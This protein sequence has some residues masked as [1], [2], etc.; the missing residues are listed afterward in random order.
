MKIAE[1]P[2]S[3]VRADVAA[4]TEDR[5][6]GSRLAHAR[7][8][9]G[10]RHRS[11]DAYE[12]RSFRR[13]GDVLEASGNVTLDRVRAIADAGVGLI[14]IGVLTHSAPALDPTML[15]TMEVAPCPR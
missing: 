3:A 7:P 11:S 6:S 2:A 4:S 5:G 8:H 9:G 15:I 14:S 1:F 13:F 12:G 10:G